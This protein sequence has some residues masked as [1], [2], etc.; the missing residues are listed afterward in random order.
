MR[1]SR[2]RDTTKKAKEEWGGGKRQGSTV[3]RAPGVTG[4]KK[5]RKNLQS[6][7]LFRKGGI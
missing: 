5:T 3:M 2:R 1:K 4:V 6:G 7:S